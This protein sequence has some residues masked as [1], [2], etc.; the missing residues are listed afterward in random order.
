MPEVVLSNLHKKFGSLVA[1]DHINLTV[2]D[3]QFLTLLGP[4][5]C[6]KTTTLRLIAGFLKPDSGEI[7]VGD[8]I[9]SSAQKGTYIPPEKR[10]MALV[11]QSYAL[12]PHMNVMENVMFGLK[13]RKVP[14]S[15]AKERALESLDLV[16]LTHLAERF[17]HQLSGGQQQRVSFARAIATEPEV[18]LL[19]EPLSNLDAKLRES[20]RFELRQLHNKLNI[21]TIYVTHDQSEA[22]I[23]SDEIC[24]MYEGRILQS[25]PPKEIYDRPN[26]CAVADFIGITNLL[27]A[28][29]TCDGDG[30]RGALIR[31]GHMIYSRES[32]NLPDQTEVTISVRPEHIQIYTSPP[33]ELRKNMLKGKVITRTF[34]GSYLDYQV[35]IE[36]ESLRLQNFNTDVSYAEREEIYLWLNPDKVTILPEEMK[37]V[38]LKI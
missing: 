28:T 33:E 21:T 6:G 31:S 30:N 17:P 15:K 35:D 38:E 5:G 19:D 13:A 14:V 7:R 20:M 32:I 18:L 16:R 1:V 34:V 22:I 36:G 12:W 26:C 29:V 3:G 24:L 9:V 8:R 25:C 11:F 10:K 23:L 4:S 2:K 27:P 37:K